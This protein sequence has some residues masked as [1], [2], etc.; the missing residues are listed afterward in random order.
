LQVLELASLF[1]RKIAATGARYEKFP[2]LQEKPGMPISAMASALPGN[3]YGSPAQGGAHERCGSHNQQQELF[4]M[5]AARWP[6]CK[7]AGLEFVDEAV[8]VD[9]PGEPRRVAAAFAVNPRPVSDA[10]RHK[11]LGYASDRR[12]PQRDK[13]EG[14]AIAEGA[15]RSRTVPLD[16]W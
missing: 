10:W 16:L 9:K 3:Q 4:L 6:L 12:V 11:N 14:E 15:S 1:W 13:A 5:V 7:M 8:P 2:V